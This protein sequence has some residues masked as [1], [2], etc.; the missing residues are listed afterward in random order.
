MVTL[1]DKAL[2]VFS[3]QATWLAIHRSLFKARRKLHPAVCIL[4][5]LLLACLQFYCV[6]VIDTPFSPLVMTTAYFLLFLVEVRGEVRALAVEAAYTYIMTNMLSSASDG[7]AALICGVFVYLPPHLL[8][9]SARTCLMAVCS[10]VVSRRFSSKDLKDMGQAYPLRIF[11]TALVLFMAAA[12]VL[13]A[14]YFAYNRN[15]CIFLIFAMTITFLLSVEWASRENEVLK[16]NKDK[17]AEIAQM[18]QTIYSLE[19]EKDAMR[20][21]NHDYGKTVLAIEQGYD[22]MHQ[23]LEHINSPQFVFG[24]SKELNERTADLKR[25]RG[26]LADESARAFYARTTIGGTGIC[27]LD[28]ALTAA[29]REAGEADVKFCCRVTDSIAEV[30]EGSR[31]ID[32]YELLRVVTNLIGNAIHA[33]QKAAGD[34]RMVLC[35]IGRAYGL[36]QIRILDTGDHFQPKVLERLGDRRNT[37]DGH[38][39]GYPNIFKALSKCRASYTL[40]EFDEPRAEGY[41]KRITICF[42]GGA[43]VCVRSA[44]NTVCYERRNP[45]LLEGK[46]VLYTMF[47][48]D[49]SDEDNGNYCSFGVNSTDGQR[50][51]DLSTDFQRLAQFIFSLNSNNASPIHLRDLIDDFLE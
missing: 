16:A 29:A 42:D 6:A 34:N 22:D 21:C 19:Q 48:G 12:C 11:V 36:Y 38:G 5:T 18:Q 30:T 51:E 45:S 7:V 26:K 40:E 24:L 43:K 2:Y 17:E 44:W 3:F 28:D 23:K 35:I 39:Y 27:I 13:C 49:Y 32:P 10:L 8:T 9:T 33:A 25:I 37:T 47:D 4:H 46:G 15:F 1:L 41:T 31:A 50:Y 14:P 20:E